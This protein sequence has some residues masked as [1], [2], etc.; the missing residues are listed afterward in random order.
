MAKNL[1]LSVADARDSTSVMVPA[2]LK[3][4]D[5]AAGAVLHQLGISKEKVSMDASEVVEGKMPNVVGMGARDA[6]YQL[7]RQG[8][9]VKLHGMGY[10]SRQSI[11]PG[12]AIQNGMV[13]MLEL[14]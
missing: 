3:G 5:Q 7:E 11:A 13:C 8:V 4:D 14:K 10:V 2:V 6:V 12:T 1:K 9:K